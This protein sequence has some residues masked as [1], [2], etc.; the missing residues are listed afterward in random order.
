MW[1]CAIPVQ[2]Y[3]AFTLHG[4]LDVFCHNAGILGRE[5]RAVKGIMSFDAAELDRVL[6][7]NPLGTVL[8]MKHA[9]RAMIRGDR[10][11]GARTATGRMP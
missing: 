10:G 4:R 8:R 7:V 11:W 5:T 6:R 9:G 2:Y 1:C 3:F